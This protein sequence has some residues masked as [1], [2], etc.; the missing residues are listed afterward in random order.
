MSSW[1]HC[2]YTAPGILF[3]EYFLMIFIFDWRLRKPLR[4][5]YV[6]YVRFMWKEIIEYYH[7]RRMIQQCNLLIRYRQNILDVNCMGDRST[8]CRSGVDIPKKNCSFS[9]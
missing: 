5:L 2:C 4:Y 8:C 6:P 1:Q 3:E 9:M 7:T